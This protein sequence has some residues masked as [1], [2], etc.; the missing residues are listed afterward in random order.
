VEAARASHLADVEELFAS[1]FDPQEREQLAELLGR[2]PLAAT[3]AA[4]T[5][6]AAE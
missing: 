4:C 1:G 6:E 3:S 2:L 5:D